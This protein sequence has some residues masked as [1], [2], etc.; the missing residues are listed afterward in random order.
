MTGKRFRV[1]GHIQETDV[2]DLYYVFDEKA[3]TGV[4]E[5]QVVLDYEETIYGGVYSDQTLGVWIDSCRGPEGEVIVF[6]GCMIESELHSGINSSDSIFI[7]S[8]NR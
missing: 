8:K 2:C 4:V 1:V 5:V 6:L 3:T 7:E